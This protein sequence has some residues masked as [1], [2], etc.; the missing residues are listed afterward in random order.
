MTFAEGLGSLLDRVERLE[1]LTDVLAEQLELPQD[2]VAHARR[3]AHLCK[4]DLVSQMVGE[5]PELQGVMGGKYLLAEGEPRK[6]PWLCSSTTS[7]RAR[8]TLCP[9]PSLVLSWP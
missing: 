4:H 7:P 3:A 8:A 6:S 9:A 5:F 1:W 2:S